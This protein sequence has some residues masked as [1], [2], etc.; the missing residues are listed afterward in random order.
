M[1]EFIQG[2]RENPIKNTRRL[3]VA[4]AV[5][6]ALFGHGD[7][8]STSAQAGKKDLVS[9]T[10]TWYNN[11]PAELLGST[12]RG[13]IACRPM[14][15]LRSYTCDVLNAATGDAQEIDTKLLGRFG[16]HEIVGGRNP[17]ILADPFETEPE[18]VGVFPVVDIG[19]GPT[20]EKT[21]SEERDVKF[22]HV[23]ESANVGYVLTTVSDDN[24]PPG[25]ELNVTVVDT[26]DKNLQTII[27]YENFR[28]NSGAVVGAVLDAKNKRLVVSYDSGVNGET[29][30]PNIAVYDVTDP[31]KIV[32]MGREITSDLSDNLIPKAI[33]GDSLISI[34]QSNSKAIELTDLS[35]PNGIA[36]RVTVETGH[37]IKEIVSYGND[38]I[39]VATATE[40]I[41]YQVKGNTIK[42][43]GAGYGVDLKSRIITITAVDGGVV[44]GM[45]QGMEFVAI[46]INKQNEIFLPSLLIQNPNY[47]APFSKKQ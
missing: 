27:K 34:H 13:I 33:V 17:F 16:V 42:Q 30:K 36:K 40:L 41:P 44:I 12:P 37:D 11:N 1:F 18:N 38:Y 6:L 35:S 31:K 28:G 23:D 10:P 20:V 45:E 29:D 8:S 25:Y 26:S 24:L 7:P 9:F 46:D 43:V 19:D 39:I 21:Q 5:G 2:F 4:S 14:P 32:R 22:F 3:M 15:I 47:A